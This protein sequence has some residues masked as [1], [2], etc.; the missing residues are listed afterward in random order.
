MEE[1]E[2]PRYTGPERRQDHLQ[3]ETALA[4][5]QRLNSA[6]ATLATA[7][8][9]T[10]QKAE[11]IGL[12]DEVKRDFMVKMVFQAI[13]TTVALLI[14]V[15]YMQ[16]KF[17]HNQKSINKGHDVII[18]MQTKTEAQRTGDLADSARIAC[19]QRAG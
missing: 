3:L 17:S 14:L 7:V 18:C 15:F 5:V 9:N 12:R 13:L 19:E 2:T 1:I 4:E 10:A 8:T 11:L 16:V 6:A